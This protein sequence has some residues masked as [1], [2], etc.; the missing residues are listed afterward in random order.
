MDSLEAFTAIS[1]IPPD[2]AQVIQGGSVLLVLSDKVLD[3]TNFD[4]GFIATFGAMVGLDLVVKL[5]QQRLELAILETGNVLW[6]LEFVKGT[7]INTVFLDDI[8]AIRQSCL[9]SGRGSAPQEGFMEVLHG[10][11]LIFIMVVAR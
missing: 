7:T 1:T 3:L 8:G 5:V 10:L 9:C 4:A 6:D 11:W 2:E